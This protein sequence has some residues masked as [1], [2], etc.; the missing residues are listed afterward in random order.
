LDEAK[1][2]IALAAIAGGMYEI[3][4]DLPMLGADPDRLT[5]AKNADL[6]NMSR[7]GRASRPLDLMSYTTEDGM[8]SIFLLQESQRQAILTVFNWTQKATAHRFDLLGDLGLQS[9]GHNQV[10]DV[11]DPTHPAE[12][13][14]DTIAV[15]LPPH[16]VKVLK[17]IDTSI[18]ASAPIVSVHTPDAAEA[19][20]SVQFSAKA[21]P[22]F[23][24]TVYRW[25]FGDGTTA[26]GAAL[27]HSYTHPGDFTVRLLADG[28][29]GVPF[30]KSIPIKVTGKIDTRFVP[31]G[32][33]RLP[34]AQ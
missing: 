20:K 9:R 15:Q 19:G 32:K 21:D 2:S 11:L 24:V 7:L 3:G 8:P 30:E 17:I 18:P 22:A 5:L 25:E 13:N 28:I 23:P 6:M 14:L 10:F 31:S 12:N 34:Q 29:D 27:S 1:V 4:D 26:Q 16:S 33:E